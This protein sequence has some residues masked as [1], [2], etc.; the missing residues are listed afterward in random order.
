MPWRQPVFDLLAAI[1]AVAFLLLII[2]GA[3]A[4]VA[5]VRPAFRRPARLVT[6]RWQVTTDGVQARAPAL[7]MEIALPSTTYMKQPG[8]RPPWVRLVA[9]IGCGQV[10][11]DPAWPAVRAAFG[12]FLQG[13]AIAGLLADLTHADGD[14][15]WARQGTSTPSIIDMVLGE[16]VAS[17]RLELPDGIRRHDRVD[18][19]ALLILHVEPRH[20]DGQ[21]APPASPSSWRRRFERAV[22]IPGAFA[23]LLSGELGLA[24]SGDP[25]AQAGIRLEAPAT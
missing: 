18:G 12:A 15:A 16:G 19:Y 1:A 11:D 14:A 10:G 5:W 25:P 13:P 4:L 22:Q 21:P 3:V 8:D 17:A 7:A 23:A 24:T 2:V 9:Q 20:A 6:D